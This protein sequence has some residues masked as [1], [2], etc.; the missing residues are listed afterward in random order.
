MQTQLIQIKISDNQVVSLPCIKDGS[1]LIK[2]FDYEK[3]ELKY[4]AVRDAVFYKNDWQQVFSY[5]SPKIPDDE[6]WDNLPRVE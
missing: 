6:F 4:D 5:V 1:K 2:V 3:N